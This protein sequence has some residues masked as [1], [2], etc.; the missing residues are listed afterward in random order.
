MLWPFFAILWIRFSGGPTP[1]FGKI[2][3]TNTVDAYHAIGW[4]DDTTNSVVTVKFT[5]T[6]DA[7][8]DGVV[9]TSDF[10]A[11]AQNFNATNANWQQGDSNYDQIVNALDFNALA[12]N[13]GLTLTSPALSPALGSH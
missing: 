3:T 4:K 9:D 10:T 12:S 8:V 5:Y 2:R 11:L 7:T 6:G 13:F 1:H